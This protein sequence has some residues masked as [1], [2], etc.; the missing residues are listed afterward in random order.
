MRFAS[1]LVVPE[2]LVVQPCQLGSQ[3]EGPVSTFAA[4]SAQVRLQQ[5]PVRNAG[6]VG[7]AATVSQGLCGG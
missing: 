4:S 5:V 7:S 6:V 3:E 1:T 2:N